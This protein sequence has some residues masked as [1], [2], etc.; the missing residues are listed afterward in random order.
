MKYLTF[1]LIIFAAAAVARGGTAHA[2]DANT[3]IQC[4]ET[5][6]VTSPNG[7]TLQ[8]VRAIA[9][10]GHFQTDDNHWHERRS[11]KKLV[12]VYKWVSEGIWVVGIYDSGRRWGVV[13]AIA[14]DGYVLV[15]KYWLSIDNVQPLLDSLNGIAIR[16]AVFTHKDRL[17]KTVVAIAKASGD[18]NANGTFIMDDGTWFN[19]SQVSKLVPSKAGIQV[20]QSVVEMNGERSVQVVK[21]IS[22][23]G[24]FLLT[25]GIWYKRGDLTTVCCGYPVPF[26]DAPQHHRQN[27]SRA[28]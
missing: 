16:E 10:D 19:E 25:D 5:V 13:E 2:Q 28:R 17:I 14:E 8:R 24:W 7:R 6:A 1:V 3:R 15:G 4:D 11:V 9:A 18:K 26:S 23:A 12:P 20:G 22:E 21:A 27:S